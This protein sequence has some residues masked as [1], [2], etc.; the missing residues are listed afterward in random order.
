MFK[1]ILIERIP[2][3]PDNLEG[4]D[5]FV[6]TIPLGEHGLGEIIPERMLL[7]PRLNPVTL[8]C[9]GIQI[10]ANGVNG[11]SPTVSAP[12]VTDRI[13]VQPLVIIVRVDDEPVCALVDSASLRDLVSPRLADQLR[14]KSEEVKN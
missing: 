9:S 6:I 1:Q 7:N 5:E 12:R 14:L 3:N 2:R 8:F 11:T 4:P 13:V 10:P